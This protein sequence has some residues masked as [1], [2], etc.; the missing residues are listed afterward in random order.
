LEAAVMRVLVAEDMRILRDSLVELLGFH[1]DIDIVAAVE[2]GAAIVS[3]ALEQAPD[4]A[5][6]DIEM[7]NVDGLTAAEE[8]RRRLPSCRVL[9]LTNF[10]Q[11]GNLRRGIQAQVA[12]FM[13]KTSRPEDLVNAIRTVAAG[14]SVLDQELASHALDAELGPLTDR[15]LDVLRLIATGATTREVASQLHLSYGT[16]CNYLASAV[17]KLN[18]RSRIDAIRIATNAGWI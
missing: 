4:V 6:I 11:P 12:G 16:V 3:T 5:V 14:G 17:T 13:L 7:P 10:G 9:I 1:D 15:E 18:A 2:D 8:L